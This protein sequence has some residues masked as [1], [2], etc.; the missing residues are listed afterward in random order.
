MKEPN[1]VDYLNSDKTES[2]NFIES[3][4]NIISESGIFKYKDP[5]DETILHKS[6]RKFEYVLK[7]ETNLHT[8]VHHVMVFHLYANPVEEIKIRVPY[9]KGH[10]KSFFKTTEHHGFVWIYPLQSFEEDSLEHI[11]LSEFLSEKYPF[12]SLLNDDEINFLRKFQK[13]FDTLSNEAVKN[14]IDKMIKQYNLYNNT[15]DVDL[16]V[17]FTQGAASIIHNDPY[18]VLIYGLYGDT[19]YIVDKKQYLLKPGDIIKINANE[20]HQGIG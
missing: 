4:K 16:F 1:I 9:I 3:L 11:S 6:S 12:K 5:S 20:I 2:H 15:L 18:D 8:Y 13:S 17:G 7:H 10:I 19:M 14:I